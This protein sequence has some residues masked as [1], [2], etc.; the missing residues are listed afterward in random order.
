MALTA[1]PGWLWVWRKSAEARHWCC[2]W[3]GVTAWLHLYCFVYVIF[4]EPQLMKNISACAAD[5]VAAR[6]WCAP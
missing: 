1:L 6:K 2:W 5:L 3:Q 4:S